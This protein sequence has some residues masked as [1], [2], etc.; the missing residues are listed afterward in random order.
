MR[1]SVK[2]LAGIGLAAWLG[3]CTVGSFDFGR[4]TTA[5]APPSPAAEPA[6]EPGPGTYTPAPV[7]GTQ[8]PPPQSAPYPP[9]QQAAQTPPPPATYQPPAYQPPPVQQQL[10][11]ARA[12]RATAVP[13]APPPEPDAE[14]MTTQRARELCWMASENTKFKSNLDQKVKYVEKCVDDKM[15]TAGQ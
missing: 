14:V 15:R 11:A 9:P 6:T 7:R 5:S 8:L 1:A 13:S 3:G 2:S 4:G 12:A 10:P